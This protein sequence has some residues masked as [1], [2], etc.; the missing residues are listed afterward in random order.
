MPQPREDTKAMIATTPQGADGLRAVTAL[1]GPRCP[2][3]AL[4]QRVA[5]YV[6]G[7]LSPLERKNGW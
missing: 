4:R 6:Q 1:L 2:R 7:L 3:A 5:A